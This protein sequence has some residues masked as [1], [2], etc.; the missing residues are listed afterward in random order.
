MRSCCVGAF[1]R[2]CRVF[3]YLAIACRQCAIED[4]VIMAGR[5]LR[6]INR[7]VF[8]D[9]LYYRCLVRAVSSKAINIGPVSKLHSLGDI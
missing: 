9:I 6:A 7:P 4:A 3:A 8:Y 5:A 1:Y 2:E